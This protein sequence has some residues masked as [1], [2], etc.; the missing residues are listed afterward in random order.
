MRKSLPSHLTQDVGRSRRTSRMGVGS[1][2]VLPR[3]ADAHPPDTLVQASPTPASP[4]ESGQLVQPAGLFAARVFSTR[5]AL[6][7]PWTCFLLSVL[8]GHHFGVP[9]LFTPPSSPALC[10]SCLLLLTCRCSP[11][12][13]VSLPRS[14]KD[15]NRCCSEIPDSEEMHLFIL[16]R[17]ESCRTP[18]QPPAGP[19]GLGRAG[20]GPEPTWPQPSV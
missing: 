15:L 16:S 17:E 10:P 18:R 6:L 8:R 3:H 1:N 4:A 13:S 19:E 11:P 9:L 2:S 20:P 14:P 5:Q 7:R 12:L